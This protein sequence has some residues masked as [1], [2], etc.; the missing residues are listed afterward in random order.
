MIIIYFDVQ[1]LPVRLL[2]AGTSIFLTCSHH[3]LNTTFWHKRVFSV[4]FVFPALHWE[5]AI[6]SRCPSFLQSAGVPFGRRW[7]HPTPVLL[8]GKPHGRRSLVGCNPWGRQESDTTEWL[9]FHFSFIGEGNGNPLPCSCLE[10]PRNGGAWWAAVCGVA[11]SQT[12]LN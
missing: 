7:W 11:Q 3:S 4:L 9:R 2:Q 10:N 6:S 12:R 1:I 5:S 8:P